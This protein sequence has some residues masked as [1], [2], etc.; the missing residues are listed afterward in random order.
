M[1][2]EFITYD[3]IAIAACLIALAVIRPRNAFDLSRC[4][5]WYLLIFSA[6]YILRPTLSEITGDLELYQALRIGSFE[7]HWQLMTIAVPL[8]I[9]TF[10]IGYAG[11]APSRSGMRNRS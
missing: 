6:T 10:G 4:A 2:A 9:I 8:A 7:D 3:T 1:S 11:A 5:G